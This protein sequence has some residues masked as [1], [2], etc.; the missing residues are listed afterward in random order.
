M[1]ADPKIGNVQKRHRETDYSCSI[2][3][4]KGRPELAQNDGFRL[5]YA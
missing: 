2:I 4:R 5:G 1:N 3:V